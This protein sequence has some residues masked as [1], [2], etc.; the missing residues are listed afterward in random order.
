MAAPLA[1]TMA[2]PSVPEGAGAV[3]WRS[4]ASV[5][6]VYA[7]AL[8][9]LFLDL[10]FSLYQAV[11]FPLYG[12]ARVRRR[13]YFVLDRARLPYLDAIGKFNCAYCSYANAVLAYAREI[14]ART[15][16]YWCPIRH[17]RTPGGTHARYELFL[18][19]GDGRDYAARTAA[20]RRSLIEE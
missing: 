6:F 14:A 20:L 13:D 12:I 1:R 17:E 15:E 18:P 2:S 11:C 5:P 3:P 8:P 10:G 7:V 9:L 19:Y 16:Q 4:L